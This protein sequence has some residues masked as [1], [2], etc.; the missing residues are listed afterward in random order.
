MAE[1]TSNGGNG[2]IYFIVGALVAVVIGFGVYYFGGM[3]GTPSDDAD[4][5]ISVNEDGIEVDE[6]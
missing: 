4:F 2:A 5:S 3:E 1:N 6:S